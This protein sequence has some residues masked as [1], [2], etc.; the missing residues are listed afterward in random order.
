M[1]SQNKKTHPE[2]IL[3]LWNEGIRSPKEIHEKTNIP[4]QTIKFYIKKIKDTGSVARKKGSGCPKKITGST[5]IAIGQYLRRDP[6]VSSRKLE[7]KLTEKGLDVSYRTISKHLGSLGYKNNVPLSTPM[8]TD[9][10]KERRV[11][12]AYAHLDD[13]PFFG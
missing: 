10:H 12:W 5:S 11:E 9:A 6:S 13:N 4:L 2:V 3:H 1:S 8:L 7:V